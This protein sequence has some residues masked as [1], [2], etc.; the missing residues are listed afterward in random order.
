M[1]ENK[2]NQII[3]SEEFALASDIAEISLDSFAN[4]GI[5]KD[6]PIIGTIVK[7]LNIGNT[8]GDRIFTDKLIHFLKEIDNLDQEFILK[9][10]RYIDD[11]EKHNRKVGEKILEIINRIDSEG[12]PQIIGRLFRNFINKQFSYLDFLKLADIVEKSFYYDLI[13]LKECKNGKFYIDL[14]KELYNSDLVTVQGIGSFDATEEERA[15]F[16]KTTFLITSKG[17]ML[18]DFGLK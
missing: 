8:I 16:N 11:S 3:K 2:L 10:I 7:L 1:E 15:E 17:A 18:L 13:L 9:E 14:D 4:D 6:V 12:K 5:I